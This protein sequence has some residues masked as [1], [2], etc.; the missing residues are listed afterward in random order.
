M[1]TNAMNL[2]LLILSNLTY[3]SKW[4][5]DDHYKPLTESIAECSEMPATF[6][7]RHE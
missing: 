5:K 2:I 3:K 6:L 4:I 7:A 1:I